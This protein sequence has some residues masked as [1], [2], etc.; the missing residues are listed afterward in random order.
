MDT[1]SCNCQGFVSELADGSNFDPLD[2]LHA[3][4]STWLSA[5]G[6]ALLHSRP[7]SLLCQLSRLS[8]WMGSRRLAMLCWLRLLWGPL[9]S[10]SVWG[11][12]PWWGMRGCGALLWA[13]PSCKRYRQRSAPRSPMMGLLPWLKAA[14]N[15]RSALS[16]RHNN[17]KWCWWCQ[18]LDLRCSCWSSE[19][20]DIATPV[21]V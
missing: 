8:F 21:Q 19:G 6:S 16:Q 11:G 13:A 15:F 12:V 4:S 18:R 20:T 10:I 14:R 3:G 9:L 2:V 7:P 17:L 5:E 1:P